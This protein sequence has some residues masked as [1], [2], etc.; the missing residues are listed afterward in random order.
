MTFVDSGSSRRAGWLDSQG[1]D[2][3]LPGVGA[4]QAPTGRVD[5]GG[6]NVE[7]EEMLPQTVPIETGALECMLLLRQLRDQVSSAPGDF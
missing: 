7:G 3:G 1:W 2:S 6:G 4:G 5:R